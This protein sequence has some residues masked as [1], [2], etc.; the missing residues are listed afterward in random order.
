MSGNQ[1]PTVGDEWREVAYPNRT[2]RVFELD[3]NLQQARCDNVRPT[4]G[5]KREVRIGYARLRRNFR[6]VKAGGAA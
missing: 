6:R 1:G 5:E 4:G 2:L 3:E